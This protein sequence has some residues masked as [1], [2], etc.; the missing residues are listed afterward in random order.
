MTITKRLKDKKDSDIE[1]IYLQHM[2]KKTIA[3]DFRCKENKNNNFV[4]IMCICNYY[5][6]LTIQ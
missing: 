1:E 4:I 6:T 3:I 2:R 5:N